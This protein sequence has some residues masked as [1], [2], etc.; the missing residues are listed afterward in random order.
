[1]ENCPYDTKQ[2]PG[3]PSFPPK[4]RK[5]SVDGFFKKR[6][7]SA[8][9]SLQK[10]IKRF[11]VKSEPCPILQET[12]GSRTRNCGRIIIF[13]KN[14]LVHRYTVKTWSCGLHVL[15]KRITRQQESAPACNNS[16]SKNV[17]VHRCTVKTWSC[18]F[19]SFEKNNYLS[20]IPSWG[21]V[22]VEKNPLPRAFLPSFLLHF[23][24]KVTPR[25]RA[26]RGRARSTA[27]AP[28]RS[29]G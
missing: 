29:I 8:T 27:A 24:E 14:M 12:K 23:S 3:N 7:K 15:R 2:N 6:V 13:L 19:A 16:F 22:S 11:C 20:T 25:P 18:G 17:F 5:I 9:S 4:V 10:V 1:M 21:F 28:H 26:E